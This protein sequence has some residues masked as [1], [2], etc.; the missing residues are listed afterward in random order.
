LLPGVK[1]TL[2]FLRSYDV[3][4]GITTGYTRPMLDQVLKSMKQQ[5]FEV[6][7]SCSSDEVVNPRPQGGQIL[8]LQ[9]R[10]GDNVQT[11]KVGDTPA[12]MMEGRD[13]KCVSI[14]ILEHSNTVREYEI[15]TKDPSEVIA[16]AKKAYYDAGANH[17]LRRFSNLMICEDI[18]SSSF[19]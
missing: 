11:I 1:E 9:Q 12:D 4:I 15:D 10:L 16:K 5:G 14:G 3:K 2:E 18:Y 7:L 13:A 8:A 19:S 17:V 6:D